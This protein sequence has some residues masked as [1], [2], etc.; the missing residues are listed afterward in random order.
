A[1]AV[2]G[3][4]GAF[5]WGL[6]SHPSKARANL[7]AG[8]PQPQAQPSKTV[9]WTRHAGE[10]TRRILPDPLVN[11]L[12]VRLVQAGHPMGLDLSRLL[13]LKI[14]LAVVPALLFLLMGK[15]LFALIAAVVLFFLPDYWVVS[16]RD[17]RQDAMR[18]KAA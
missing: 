14:T 17:E 4:V 15:P 3:A 10:F 1:T 6:T 5:W 2:V 16:K 11:G 18:H 12:E 9:N 8:L 13:G 7:F